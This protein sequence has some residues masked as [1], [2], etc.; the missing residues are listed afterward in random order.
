MILHYS[1]VAERVN[2]INEAID[3]R[4]VQLLVPALTHPQA[5]IY[6]VTSQCSQQYLEELG[7]LKDSK[8]QAGG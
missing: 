1:A 2:V 5:N 3:A 7:S 4:D 8:K 6:G